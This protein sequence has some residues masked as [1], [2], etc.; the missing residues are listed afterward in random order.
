MEEPSHV[1]INSKRE[2]SEAKHSTNIGI[3]ELSPYKSVNQHA[4]LIAKVLG[5]NPLVNDCNRTYPLFSNG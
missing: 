2:I 1:K 5:S 4:T 3:K